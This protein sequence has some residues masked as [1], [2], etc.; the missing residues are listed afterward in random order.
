MNLI[1][2][3]TFPPDSSDLSYIFWVMG[4]CAFWAVAPF[5]PICSIHV[6]WVWGVLFPTFL[7]SSNE[8]F[9]SSLF[10]CQSCFQVSWFC[11]YF[12]KNSFCF[13]DLL[14][15]F[16][17]SNSSISAFV[18]FISFFLHALGLFCSFSRFCSRNL[19]DDWKSLFLSTDS[20][21]PCTFSSHHCFSELTYIEILYFIS[22]SSIFKISFETSSLTWIIYK[23]VVYFPRF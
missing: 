23:C 2:L 6:C 22:F 7:H 12:Q 1:S 20:M 3:F 5:H 21:W 14:Y 18:F 13:I 8:S 15:G 11:G 10:P 17:L 16:L 9:V 4:V 19:D